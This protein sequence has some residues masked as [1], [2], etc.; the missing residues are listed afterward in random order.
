MVSR[1]IVSIFGGPW[2]LKLLCQGNS[3]KFLKF[4][5]III[6]NY[7]NYKNNSSVAWNSIILGEPCFPHG[8]KNIFISGGAIIGNNCVIFQQVTIGS[9]NLV[10]S[11]GIGTPKIGSNCYIGAGAKIIGNVIIE[12]N[13][14]IGANAVVYRHVPI[15]SIVVSGE[16]KNICN[17]EPLNNKFYSFRHGKRVYFNNGKWFEE[18]DP[19]ALEIFS[20]SRRGPI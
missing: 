15:N 9:N 8:W 11:K 18:L 20:K 12:D 16:Q 5:L 19:V 6:Y 14:R 3:N 10:D 7:Y 4:F 17:N 13:C 1:L 2:K